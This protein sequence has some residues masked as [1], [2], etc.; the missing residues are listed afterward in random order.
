MVRSEFK[1]EDDLEELQ[2]KISRLKKE[3]ENIV[4]ETLHNEGAVLIKD[5]I[6]RLLPRSGRTWKGKGKAAADANSVE[7]IKNETGNLNVVVGSTY[8]YHYLYFPDD[9]SNTLYHAGGLHFMKKAA[10][11]QTG[12]IINL[13]ME[14]LTRAI[15]G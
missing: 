9:G 8:K 5:E 11:N 13:C 12:S 15:E 3:G 4:N 6:M 2:I 14:R 7:K 10:E 1:V